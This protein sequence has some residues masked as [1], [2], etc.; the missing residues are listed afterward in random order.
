M[1][2]QYNRILPIAAPSEPRHLTVTR[3]FT[4][5]FVVNWIP[6]Q[7]PNGP[8]LY[9]LNYGT[10]TTVFSTVNTSDDTY[11]NLTGLQQNTPYYIR[12]VAVNYLTFSGPART[13]GEWITATTLEQSKMIILP[14]V[15]YMYRYY[16]LQ[17]YI[18]GII[19]PPFPLL[20]SSDSDMS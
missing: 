11:Y 17:T 16:T 3:I 14:K 2:V 20:V 6:P 13:E 9:E 12:V 4:D 18:Q 19:F 1:Y 8:V 7:Q 10:N 5:G 15:E